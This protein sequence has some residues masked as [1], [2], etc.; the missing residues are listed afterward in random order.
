MAKNPNGDGSVYKLKNG[1]WQAAVVVGYNA[2]GKPIRK[3][4][5]CVSRKQ[6]RDACKDLIDKFRESPFILTPTV[7]EFSRQYMQENQV[8][9][10]AP[11]TMVHYEKLL[12]LHVNP[13]IGAVLLSDLKPTVVQEWINRLVSAGTGT[14]TVKHSIKALSTMLKRA[15]ALELI[16]SNPCEAVRRPKSEGKKITAFTLEESKH[17]IRWISRSSSPVITL[18]HSAFSF[19]CHDW[20]IV[21]NRLLNA[22][23]NWV[24]R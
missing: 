2:A 17:H 14:T 8:R 24:D 22:L 4:K 20:S 23:L 10:L 6:A 12:R 9:G 21:V 18:Y 16:L 15:H 11:N 5:T 19:R 3:T 7:E 1:K 13:H